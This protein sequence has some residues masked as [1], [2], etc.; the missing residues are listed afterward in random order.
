VSVVSGTTEWIVGIA[1]MKVSSDPRDVLVT[2][3][4]GSCL[5]ICVYDREARVAGLLHAMLPSSVGFGERSDEQPL[6]FVDTGLCCLFRACYA[7]GAQKSRMALTVAGGASMRHLG[8]GESD[9]FQIGPRNARALERL[10]A[11]N[12][13]TVIRREVGGRDHRFMSIR[14]H[15]GAV[16]V[17][18]RALP[19]AREGVQ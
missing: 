7:L 9:V 8:G 11:G 1:E 13:V 3:A 12:G 17:G 18:E 6:M 5:G 16:R 14:V 10:A 19:G 15:D 4:L 2:Y